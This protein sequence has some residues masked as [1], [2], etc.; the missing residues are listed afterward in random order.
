MRNINMLIKRNIAM[1]LHGGVDDQVKKSEGKWLASHLRSILYRPMTEMMNSHIG[2]R[3][4]VEIKKYY[5][6]KLQH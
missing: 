1:T 3:T 5:H 6:D 2:T 4:T